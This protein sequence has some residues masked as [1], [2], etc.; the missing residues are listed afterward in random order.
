MMLS[1][2]T[3]CGSLFMAEIILKEAVSNMKEKTINKEEKYL[4]RGHKGQDQRSN[5]HQIIV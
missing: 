3:K 4:M 1:N 2:L 5:F